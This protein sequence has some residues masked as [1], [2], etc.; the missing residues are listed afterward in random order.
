MIRFHPLKRYSVYIL[1]L[2]CFSVELMLPAGTASHV[3]LHGVFVEKEV[4]YTGTLLSVFDD[5]HTMN[6]T[7]HGIWKYTDIVN[8]TTIYGPLHFT[9]N[10]SL[11]P[12]TTTTTTTT[13]EAPS[14][15]PTSIASTIPESTMGSQIEDVSVK[16]GGGGAMFFE[17]KKDPEKNGS[18][19]ILSLQFPVLGSIF[20]VSFFN[21][22]RALWESQ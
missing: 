16:I 14:T 6:R 1:T 8:I 19:R 21:Y 12:T 22:I 17:K 4:P 3:E 15:S 20:V 13:T 11:V 9:H 7:I 2:L 5:K 10:N 18:I